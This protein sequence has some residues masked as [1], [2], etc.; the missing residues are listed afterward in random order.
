[1]FLVVLPAGLKYLT[2]KRNF[3]TVAAN[4]AGTK[5][6]IV[7]LCV[8]A[9]AVSTSVNIWMFIPGKWSP[10]LLEGRLD[11]EVKPS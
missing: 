5:I 6:S 3:S 9:F 2:E 11:V 4:L 8:G 7:V 10:T 1:M